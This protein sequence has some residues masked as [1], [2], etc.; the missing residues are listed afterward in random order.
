MSSGISR[1]VQGSFVGTGLALA[2]AKVGFKPRALLF[3]NED[4]PVFGLHIQGM[5]DASAAKQKGSATTYVTSN[6]VMLTNT[7]FSI[8][9][10]TDLNVDGERTWFVAWE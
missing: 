10:D 5:A 3:F 1:T 6:G 7:G 9:A 8:G 2:I 4:D